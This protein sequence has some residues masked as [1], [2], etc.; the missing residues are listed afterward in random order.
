MISTPFWIGTGFMKCVDTTLEEA[1]VSVGSFV[2]EA[3]I[4]VIDIEEVLVAR[5]VCD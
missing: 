1:D 2:V 4:R 5:I 3:A